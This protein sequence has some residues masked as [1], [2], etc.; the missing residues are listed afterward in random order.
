MR[1]FRKLLNLK[2]KT[3]KYQQTPNINTHSDIQ[4][5]SVDAINITNYSKVEWLTAKGFRL[6]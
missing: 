2:K 3:Q 5:P 4:M 6:Q 1:N